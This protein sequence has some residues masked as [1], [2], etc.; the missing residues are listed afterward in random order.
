L[1]FLLVAWLLTSAVGG[2]VVD[3]S[4]APLPGV[5]VELQSGD[6][7]ASAVTD[8]DGRFVFAAVPPGQAHLAFRLINFGTVR[9][10]VLVVDG[11]PATLAVVMRLALSADV[12]VTG[13]RT[14]R[15]IADLENP[16]ENIVGIAASA[17]QGAITGEQLE[18][19]PISRAGE[20]LETV[21]GLVVSQHS[22]EGKA[23]QYYLRG[24][25][26][27]HGTDFATTIAGVPVNMPTHAHGHGYSDNNFLLPELVSGVQYKKG[28]YFADEG[29]FSAAGA[30]NVNYV[31]QLAR[32]LAR[33]SLG[34]QGWGRVLAAASPAVKGGHLLG[35]IELSHNDGPWD[36]PDDYRKVNGVV[37]YSRGDARDGYSVT[38]MMYGADWDAT[39][40]IPERAVESGAISRFGHIDP[41]DGGR[42]HRVS[43]VLDL[44]RSAARA[45]TRA[46]AYVMHYGLKLFSNFTYFLDDPVDGD[47]FEQFERRIVA[48]GRMTHRRLGSFFGRGTENAV[49]VQ[50]RHDAIGAIGLYK[51]VAQQR[52][53]TVR[54]DAVNQSSFAAFAQSEIEWSRMA[55][56]TFGVR[57]DVFRFDVGAADLAN[58]GRE[59][60]ALI[61]PKFGT[62]FG[63]W[64]GTEFYVNAG[65]G[66]HS[67]DARGA[68]ITR[69]PIS[70]APVDRV[71]PLARARGAEIGL[72]TVRLR[73]IQTTVALWALG[74]DSEL[75][76]IG[77]A[78]T[79][80]ASEPTR[81]YGIEWA[82]YGRLTPWMTFDVDVS[83][84]RAEFSGDAEGLL[85]PGAVDRV[86]QAGV[87][88][89]PVRPLFGSLRLRHFGP[90]P[91]T[92]DGSVMSRSTTILNAELGYSL[93]SRA[94][95][96]V[97]AFNLLN[98][99]AS[100]IDY[101]YTSR[102]PGEPLAGVADVHTHPTPPRSAR[103]ALHV[104]F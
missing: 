65:M 3:D 17:S 58:A 84:S 97:E 94:R 27:D 63:P 101:F 66:F 100:D 21:P 83:F 68:T 42:T 9:R 57:T 4:G 47:Q 80:E 25:N 41:T 90:R 8:T 31:N 60:D 35:A 11:Q 14:F 33:I 45:S 75:L 15:N 51:T 92:E 19:R 46:S 38:G 70:G 73:G 78:G 7:A 59:H 52:R 16:A 67:N 24:F 103:I 69:D 72:R 39:D 2:R 102:L 79:T 28:P 37:R 22:G 6:L 74:L 13:S 50:I 64:A 48:G 88:F 29:D 85:I 23:N 53:E 71:T 86:V 99:A 36:R 10:D 93:S 20:V 76:F 96:V 62:V 95:V 49:G 98:T 87:T 1:T 32:P 44:Q 55:R 12:T 104:A 40:Q 82:N 89:E 43:G 54:E 5:A 34:G 77:D 61:S 18:A 30:A 81:R 56:S 26:L 91:L